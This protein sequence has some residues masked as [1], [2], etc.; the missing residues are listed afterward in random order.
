MEVS[1]LV[2]SIDGRVFTID[3]GERELKVDTTLL[4]YNPMDDVGFQQ[5]QEGDWV[6]ASGD[7]AMNTFEDREI[8]A[9]SVVKLD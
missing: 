4:P 6:R 7:L 2:T 3:T 1:G 8:M 5:V 9:E